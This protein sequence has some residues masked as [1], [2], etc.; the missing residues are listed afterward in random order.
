MPT[1]DVANEILLS[2]MD[3][4]SV[5]IA[6]WVATKGIIDPYVNKEK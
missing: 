3:S 6:N 1:S 2:F 5:P 4:D